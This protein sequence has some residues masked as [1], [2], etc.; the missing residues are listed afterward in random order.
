LCS[1]YF[2]DPFTI[3]SAAGVLLTTGGGYLFSQLQKSKGVGTV[4]DSNEKT[5][6]NLVDIEQSKSPLL[7][8]NTTANNH[9][10]RRRK[11]KNSPTK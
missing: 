3:W 9:Y 10:V 11:N 7:P 2:G 6:S 1:W 4:A 5:T 8:I